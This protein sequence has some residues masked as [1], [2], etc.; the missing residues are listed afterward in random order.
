M[1]DE[2]RLVPIADVGEQE[3]DWVWAGRMAAGTLA[4]IDGDPGTGKSAVAYDLTARVTSGYPMPGESARGT[5]AG[6]VLLGAEDGLMDMVAPRLRAAGADL[7]RVFV[8]DRQ[9]FG[10]RPLVIP[11]DVALI[12]DA[13]A[14]V[15]ARLVVVDPLTAF[16]DCNPASDQ[17]VRA[18]LAPL[19]RMA[20]RMRFGVLLLRH[21]T[22]G[23]GR[24]LYRGLGSIG[25]VAAA[26]T[27]M[28]TLPDPAA[29]GPHDHVLAVTK[30]NLAS[31]PALAYRTVLRDSVPAVEWRGESTFAVAEADDAGAAHHALIAASDVL[32]AVLADGPIWA[33]EVYAAARRAGVSRRTLERAKR[34]LGVVSRKRGSGVGSRWFWVLD[35]NAKN[36]QPFRDRAFDDLTGQL[37]HGDE[38][39]AP[40]RRPA[41]G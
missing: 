34:L 20:E 35:P 27:A 9:R 18:A 11:D 8:Y 3:V 4:L 33:D 10:D 7:T 22:K 28:V 26:R 37:L 40:A 14:E 38:P 21:L 5:P 6:V 12:A 41:M 24:T 13:A 19:V 31:A 30:T 29:G 17:A 25:I 1:N 2:R 16:L 15:N 36:V 39:V 23:T 32:Y